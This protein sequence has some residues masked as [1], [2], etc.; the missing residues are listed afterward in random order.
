ME[1]KKVIIL[2]AGESGTGAA[3]LAKSH[4]WD[5]MV[6]D[7]GPIKEKYK[8]E[9]R[10]LQIPFEEEGHHPESF[11]EAAVVVKSPGIPPT[12]PLIRQLRE[13][14]IAVVSEIEF[15]FGFAEAPV[16]AITGSNGKTTTTSLVHHLLVESGI[17]AGLGGNIGTSFAGLVDKGGFDC[18]VLELSSF[19]LEDIN[20]FR[21]DVSV[22]LNITP[23]HLDRYGYSL[24][25]YAAA[26]FRIA[27]NQQTSDIFVWNL[28]DPVSGREISAHPV[29]ATRLGFSREFRP[30]AAGWM[31]EAEMVI[32]HKGEILRFRF[33]EMKLMGQHNE[34]N[35]LAAI[36]AALQMGATESG[37][38][39][40]LKTFEAI[41]HRLEKVAET[42]GILAINDSKATNVDAV[43]YALEC[44]ER[45]CIWIAGGVDK[46]NDYQP[47]VPL[48]K[49]KVKAL[50]V[51]GKDK[52][53]FFQ[54]FEPHTKS[55]S[56]A[57]SMEEAVEQAFRQATKG[58][59]ILLSPACA[60]FDLFQNYEDRGRQFK[61]AVLNR[62]PA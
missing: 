57:L 38:R 2:G 32:R 11:F 7:S 10:R 49:D 16:V 8:A 5:V 56:Q 18:Y 17:R 46:G 58:D 35:T 52:D 12:A 6:S 36:L 27:A 9:L 21:P 26:K 31:E 50:I 41:E 3:I 1:G 29:K 15:A 34:A 13:K 40:G 60:S 45:P 39:N 54:V 51:L 43:W 62:V 47:L 23:D 25:A 55:L 4:G 53:K 14:G 30:E 59:C 44:M 33:D 20:S 61:Q 22:L 37:I 19:Q 28:E 48:V 42:G 24:E